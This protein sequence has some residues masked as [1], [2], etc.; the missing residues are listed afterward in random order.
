MDTISLIL[1]SLESRNMNLVTT[2]MQRL[3]KSAD[4]VVKYSQPLCP[5]HSSACKGFILES[6]FPKEVVKPCGH[7]ESMN[8]LYEKK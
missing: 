4:E 7:S 6:D 3:R 5:K 8:R 1:L 2:F